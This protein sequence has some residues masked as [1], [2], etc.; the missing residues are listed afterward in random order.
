MQYFEVKLCTL[1]QPPAGGW[2]IKQQ[3][4]RVQFLSEVIK[5][6]AS[7]GALDVV[8]DSTHFHT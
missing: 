1:I 6:R 2:Y 7:S 3:I 5:K 8:S 4:Y